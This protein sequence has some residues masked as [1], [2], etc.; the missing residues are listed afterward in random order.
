[1]RLKFLEHYQIRLRNE[2]AEA[3]IAQCVLKNLNA[4]IFKHPK[5]K[6]GKKVIRNLQI[7]PRASK[8][9]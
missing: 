6:F 4:E 1:M 2:H 8:K 9:E 3:M 7:G 5:R